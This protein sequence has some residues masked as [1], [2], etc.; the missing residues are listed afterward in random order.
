MEPTQ[1]NGQ[2]TPA[3]KSTLAPNINTAQGKKIALQYADK[4]ASGKITMKQVPA[5]YVAYVEGELKGRRPTTKA[6][7]AAG[8]KAIPMV[9]AAAAAPYIIAAVPAAIAAFPTIAAE[10]AETAKFLSTAAGKTALKKAAA[11]MAISTAFGESINEASKL[12]GYNSFGDLA[13]QTAGVNRDTKGYGLMEGAANFANPGYFIG[14]GLANRAWNSTRLNAIEINN[15]ATKALKRREILREA[16][17]NTKQSISNKYDKAKTFIVKRVNNIK[18]NTPS[19]EVEVPE[20]LS[21]PNPSPEYALAGGDPGSIRPTIVEPENRM[22]LENT[23]SNNGPE[24]FDWDAFEHI[25]G[26]NNHNA[27]RVSEEDIASIPDYLID[28][29]SSTID[30]FIRENVSPN[31]EANFI[32]ALRTCRSRAGYVEDPELWTRKAPISTDIYRNLRSHGFSRYDVDYLMQRGYTPEQLA[33]LSFPDYRIA[34]F[35]STNARAN[36]IDRHF[37]QIGIEPAGRSREDFTRTALINQAVFHAPENVGRLNLP[38]RFRV[39]PGQP[40]TFREVMDAVEYGALPENFDIFNLREAT[41]ES[42]HNYYGH[43]T[44]S[45]RPIVHSISGP[46]Y[47]SFTNSTFNYAL[48]NEL[49][50]INKSLSHMSKDVFEANAGKIKSAIEKVYNDFTNAGSRWTQNEI[51]SALEAELTKTYSSFGKPYKLTFADPRQFGSNAFVGKAVGSKPIFSSNEST[52]DAIFNNSGVNG[53]WRLSNNNLSAVPYTVENVPITFD[54]LD[55]SAELTPAPFGH[56]NGLIGANDNFNFF[57]TTPEEIQH[58]VGLLHIRPHGSDVL[59]GHKSAQ[60]LPLLN[61]HASKN[62]REGNGIILFDGLVNPETTTNN[63][64]YTI[65]NGLEDSILRNAGVSLSDL[66]KNNSRAFNMLLQN[67]TD[68]VFNAFGGKRPNMHIILGIEE[69]PESLVNFFKQ[70]K[71]G[72]IDSSGRLV[73]EISDYGRNPIKQQFMK[74]LDTQINESPN[75]SKYSYEIVYPMAGYRHLKQ[76]GIVKRK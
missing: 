43:N 8:K 51:Q 34:P 59:D 11:D 47:G 73:M 1:R 31:D 16:I 42:I 57:D 53:N 70:N 72:D 33:Q 44:F 10:V 2:I 6:I 29:D 24:N 45:G 27:P 41:P 38:E 55:K 46:S 36:A 71:L 75:K 60:S 3:V 13:L 26:T 15:L 58:N 21:K 18:E 9:A 50:N 67:T 32:E 23:S 22:F 7:D 19:V 12:S 28:A 62:A 54:I 68:R 37:R 56:R 48:D 66:T 30:Q 35:G 14:G 49:K 4:V 61:V 65:T 76:G 63:Y 5:S 40:V 74:M 17:D 64:R 39:G 25:G 52:F 69:N 20:I